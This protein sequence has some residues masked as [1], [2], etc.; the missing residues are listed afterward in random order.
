MDFK[1][2]HTLHLSIK[3]YAE[4][5]SIFSRKS[6]YRAIVAVAIV[7]ALCLL[8][9]WTFLLGLLLLFLVCLEIFNPHILNKAARDSYKQSADLNGPVTYGVSS[10]GITFS[11]TWI[12]A[13]SGWPNLVQWRERE[14]WLILYPWGLPK[15]F[16]RVSELRDAGVYDAVMERACKH[17]VDYD[18]QTKKA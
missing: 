17:G 8:W 6:R 13:S 1:F 10:D 15:I 12:Q 3:Q 18:K 5:E 2:E 9:S 14:D 4:L 7:G 11:G 16:L